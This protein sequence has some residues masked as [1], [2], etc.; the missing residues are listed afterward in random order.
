MVANGVSVFFQGHDHL[1]A[2][3][4]LDGVIYQEVPMP[5]DS[6]YIIGVR[7]NGDSYTGVTLDGSGHVRVRVTPDSARVDYVRSYLP[8]DENATH[9]NREIAYSYKVLPRVTEV[10]G[11]PSVPVSF[12]LDQNFPNPFN[13]TTTI[14][15]HMPVSGVVSIRV[16]DLLGREVARPV[17]GYGEPGSH[18]VVWNAAGLP[19]GMY[20]YQMIVNGVSMVRTSLLLK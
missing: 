2:K 17:D 4:E 19:S 12:G 18:S 20:L 10:S 3:E 11:S 16:F 6:T 14:V 13:P 7:D 1:F 9:A 15:Y 5:S 8:A